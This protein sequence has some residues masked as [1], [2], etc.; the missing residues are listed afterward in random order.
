M[1][2]NLLIYPLRVNPNLREFVKWF[3]SIRHCGLALVN[4]IIAS[5]VRQISHIQALIC[6]ALFF[7]FLLDQENIVKLHYLISLIPKD[8]K[9]F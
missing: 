2:F 8:P 5:K 3:Q 4:L 7:K 9:D 1:L 6:L